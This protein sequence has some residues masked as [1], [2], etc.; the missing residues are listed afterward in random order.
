MTALRELTADEINVLAGIVTKLRPHGAPRW[1]PA[2]V[3]AAFVKVAH[4]DAANVLTAAIRLACDR[5]AITPAQIAI[6]TSECWREK[7]SD[8]QPP[9]DRTDPALLCDTCGQPRHRCQQ[10][11][12]TFIEAGRARALPPPDPTEAVARLRATLTEAPATTGAS[13]LEDH[14]AR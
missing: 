11:G 14:D 1:Q 12:H 2:G 4:L 8:W 10:A 6:T 9:P 7:P 3:R 13:P 5:T